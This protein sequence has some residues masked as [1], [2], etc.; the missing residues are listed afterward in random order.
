MQVTGVKVSPNILDINFNVANGMGSIDEHL[1]NAFFTANPSEHLDWDDDARH[2][3][4]VVNNSK[5]D[6]AAIGLAKSEGLTEF[7]DNLVIRRDREREWNLDYMSAGARNVGMD[8][9]LDR[10]V[11]IV[12][13]DNRVSLRERSLE[14]RPRDL[15]ENDSRRSGGIID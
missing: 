2:G 12:K 5:A 10:A 13:H 1:V 8:G 7:I 14:E 3:S 9:L 11:G 15:L 4:Y 6:S